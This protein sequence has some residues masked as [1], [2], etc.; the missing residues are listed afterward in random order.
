MGQSSLFN[1]E[2]GRR[3]GT[4][5]PLQ[6]YID[7]INEERRKI[8][9]GL[10]EMVKGLFARANVRPEAEWKVIQPEA[11]KIGVTHFFDTNKTALERFDYQTALGNLQPERKGLP[12]YDDSQK[13]LGTIDAN[14][15]LN[16]RKRRKPREWVDPPPP[17][18]PGIGRQGD[19]AAGASGQ[20]QPSPQ[21]RGPFSTAH[22]AAVAAL[23]AIN[24]TSVREDREYG[25]RVCRQSDGSFIY[26]GP[27]GGTRDSVRPGSCPE[28]TTLSAGYH[29]HGGYSPYANYFSGTDIRNANRYGVPTY[30]A[31]YTSSIRL[32][33]PQKERVTPSEDPR[34]VPNAGHYIKE[35]APV[36]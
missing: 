16:Q 11:F 31:S 5:G 2:E 25:G 21:E 35:R 32:Y 18:N 4:G 20:R 33:D 28:N 3:P 9:D 12:N 19:A 15:L 1:F 23:R 24:A 22:D 27:I 10:P 30:M 13:N 26:T 8:S 29:T 34:D 7:K 6:S 14:F 17:R 36:R